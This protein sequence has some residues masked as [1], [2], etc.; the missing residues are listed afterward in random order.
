MQIPLVFMIK[1]VW[2]SFDHLRAKYAIWGFTI[3]F[4][5]LLLFLYYW[6]AEEKSLFG[7]E[8]KYLNDA[9]RLI[10]TGNYSQNLLWPAG[11]TYVL[12]DLGKVVSGLNFPFL[13]F[14]QIF[15]ILLWMIKGV[16]FYQLL[17]KLLPTEISR[18]IT[19]ALF[20]GYPTLTAFSHYV[21]PETV[22][23]TCYLGGWQENFV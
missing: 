19:L 6:G 12:A 8:N 16:I 10:E 5:L 21:W 17:K 1:D 2:F 9:L 18:L 7:D 20:L 3:S 11:Y 14:I 13:L 23:L 22:H 15:Q 4:N